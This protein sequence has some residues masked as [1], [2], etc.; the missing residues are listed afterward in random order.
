MDG[1]I[2]QGRDLRADLARGFSLWAIFVNHIPGNWLGYVTTKNWS[3]ADATEAFVLLAG[4]AAGIA[5]GRVMDRQGWFF[6][7][8]R[9]M[10]RVFTLYVAHIFLLVVFTAQVGYSAAALDSMA[11]LDELH[12]DP[13]TDNAYQALLEALMLSYQPS[14]L[15]ILPLYIVLLAM[16]ALAL[17]LLRRRW[18]MLGISATVYAAARLWSVNFT[19]WG[20]G[21]W[22]FN[23]LAWQLLFFCGCAMGYRPPDGAPL[24]VPWRRWIAALCMVLLAFSFFAVILIFFRWDWAEATL[25]E[26]LAG[27]IA[28]IDKTALHPMRLACILAMAYLFAHLVPASAAWLRARWAQ[29]FVLMG[30]Q[31]LP[32]FCCGIALSFFG[33]LALERS[34]ALGMQVAVNL[35]GAAGLIGVALL[36]GWYGVEMRTLRKSSL[37]VP[38]TT[39]RT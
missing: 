11:Y 13:F 24:S 6:A 20:G 26:A 3:L 34:D 25:P 28:S 21:G 8:S 39:D 19:A 37:P 17:P 31:A 30:Q 18:L 2:R 38:V 4:F 9:V 36:T 29:P 12:L 7:A 15:N 32:V 1:L 16:L 22:F 23:P 14:F 10:G 27:F 35:V 5:Y 33:R